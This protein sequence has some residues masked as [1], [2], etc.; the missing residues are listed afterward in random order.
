MVSLGTEEPGPKT[1]AGNNRG[2]SKWKHLSLAEDG[3]PQE[4]VSSVLWHWFVKNIGMSI[5]LSEVGVSCPG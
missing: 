3:L 1:R 2:S 4:A 5:L